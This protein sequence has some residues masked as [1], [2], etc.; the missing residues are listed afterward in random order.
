MPPPEVIPRGGC[1]R[2]GEAVER[3]RTHPGVVLVQLGEIA[4]VP[5]AR[6]TAGKAPPLGQQLDLTGGD[7]VRRP[8]RLLARVRTP[9]E[10]FDAGEHRSTEILVA[11]SHPVVRAV[12]RV[13]TRERRDDA[14]V[15]RV[16]AAPQ[17]LR[18][19]RVFPCDRKEPPDGALRTVYLD[20]FAVAERRQDAT[21]GDNAR[22]AVLACHDGGMTE[23]TADLGHH[24][25]GHGEEGRP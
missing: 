25:G 17:D 11:P 6:H 15:V 21:G 13:L 12:S 2:A 8:Q 19:F 4:L 5:V 9:V 14:R 7:L 1:P 22:N 20:R 3:Q 24:R 18:V 16:V 10:G 23:R